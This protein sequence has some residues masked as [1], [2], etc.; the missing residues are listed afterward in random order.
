MDERTKKEILPMLMQEDLV[1]G[2]YFFTQEKL[3]MLLMD[4]DIKE[5]VKVTVPSA[6]PIIPIAEA[7]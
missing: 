6:P 3:L 5:L 1:M 7:S 2:L 4:V